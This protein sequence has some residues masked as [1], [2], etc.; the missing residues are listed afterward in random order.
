MNNK[1]VLWI[2]G[3]KVYV[4][5]E[6]FRAYM[7]DVWRNEKREKKRVENEYSYEFMCENGFD[8]QASSNQKSV[9]DFVMDKLMIENLLVALDSLDEIE[10]ALINALFFQ[11]KTERELSRETGVP[12]KTIAYR[13]FKALN[14]LRNIL[15]KFINI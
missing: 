4:N 10:Y 1:W 6:V 3:K 7:Q 15:E 9:E 14:E 5:E 8:G 11:G 2:N 13:K 12:R